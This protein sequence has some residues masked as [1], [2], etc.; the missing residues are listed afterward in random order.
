MPP[1]LPWMFVG[2]IA[3]MILS[4]LASKYQER[5]HKPIAFAQDFISGAILISLLGVLIPDAFPAFPLTSSDMALPNF[6]KMLEQANEDM[7]IQVGPIRR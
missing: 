4:F 3:F 2:G 1:W 7:D 6:S 5:Q